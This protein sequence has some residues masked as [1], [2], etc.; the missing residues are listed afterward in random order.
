M[1][2]KY[3]EAFKAKKEST[4][5]SEVFRVERLTLPEAKTASGLILS[6]SNANV[7]GVYSNPPVYVVILEVGAGYE[8]ESGK[9]VQPENYAPGQVAL[10]GAESVQWYSTLPFV[11]YQP[12]TIGIVSHNH[13]LEKYES[14][15]SFKAAWEAIKV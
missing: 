6:N 15:E 9:V 13:I 5:R 12:F 14:I 4:L 2:S 10:V 3:L 8:D 11:G 7:N 1:N